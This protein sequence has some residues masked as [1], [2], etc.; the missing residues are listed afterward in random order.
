MTEAIAYVAEDDPDTV[1]ID[2]A[3]LPTATAATAASIAS[4]AAGDAFELDCD[5]LAENVERLGDRPEP[6]RRDGKDAR[7]FSQHL[8]SETLVE[9][10][11]T[12]EDD[13]IEFN[14]ERL[15]L[16]ARTLEL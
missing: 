13:E 16:T 10:L 6:L 3:V 5:A 12:D 9:L 4:T 2:L 1:E 7:E 8:R 15:G 14:P 11:S